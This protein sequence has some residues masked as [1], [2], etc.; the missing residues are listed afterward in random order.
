MRTR[1]DGCTVRVAGY[2]NQMTRAAAPIPCRNSSKPPICSIPLACRGWALSIVAHA[3]MHKNAVT[4]CRAW[5]QHTHNARMH[6]CSR[7]ATQAERHAFPL[8]SS[9]FLCMSVR[10]GLAR[11]SRLPSSL[12]ILT[13]GMSASGSSSG[14]VS[15]TDRLMSAAR[16]REAPPAARAG[17]RLRA[18]AAPARCRG[19]QP[20][21]PSTPRAAGRAGVK[22]CA[23][24][25]AADSAATAQSGLNGRRSPVLGP[26]FA[27]KHASLWSLGS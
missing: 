25:S 23:N 7:V 5:T 10:H 12:C 17:L 27:Q 19:A 1:T 8:L 20:P 9:F 22:A 6:S 11:Q 26:M 13:A 24:E 4:T 15:D 16:S 3:R 14:G 18:L 21:R 2:T